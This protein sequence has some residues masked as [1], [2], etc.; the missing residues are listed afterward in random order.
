MMYQDYKIEEWKQY[1]IST[2]LTCYLTLPIRVGTKPIACK[3]FFLIYFTQLQKRKLGESSE[4]R[5]S[6][7][8]K[9]SL[10]CK[11]YGM[12]TLYMEE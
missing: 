3:A 5:K 7:K 11:Q 12:Y 1:N 8:K 6:I 9:K 2:L 10:V 4:E